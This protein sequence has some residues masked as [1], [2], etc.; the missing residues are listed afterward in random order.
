MKVVQLLRTLRRVTWGEPPS[1]AAE[2]SYLL[3]IDGFVLSYV[4]LLYW[5]N[6]LSRANLSNAYVSG[7][8]EDLNMKGNEFNII[9][10]CFNVGYIVAMIPHNL[11][12]LKVRPRYWLS[13][14]AFAWGVLTLSLYKVHDY[15]QVCVIRFFVAVFESVTFGGTHLILGSYYD[16][17]LLPIRTAV[18]TS[19][20]LLGSLFSGVLQAAIY[21]NMDGYNGIRGWRWL[22]IIDFL[23]TLPIVIYGLIF[24]PDEP[25]ISKPFYLTEEEHQIAL[26]RKAAKSSVKNQFNWS[27]FK[28]VFNHWHWYLFSFLWVLGGENESFVSNSLLALWLKFNNYT[29]EQRNHYPMGLYAVGVVSTISSALYIHSYGK[30]SKHW[31]MGILIGI[32]VIVSAIIHVANPH[33]TAA[34]F[35]SQYLSAFSFAGQTVFFSWANVVCMND[36]QERAIVLASM[37]MFSNAVNAWWSLLFYAADTVPEFKKGCWA[38]LATGIASIVVVVV[39]RVLQSREAGVISEVEVVGDTESDMPAKV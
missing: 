26:T 21:K 35:V 6:Y 28:R 17:N 11:I 15:K 3:K 5:L 23:I 18:F 36:L 9:N 22:F 10:T 24:F 13:F 25:N 38:L 27:I 16:E 4:C 2:R 8:Q 29:V 39:I 7:M 31:H 20:G 37:N 34:V 33:N 14:C 30:G 1:T 19:S 32:I 12:L